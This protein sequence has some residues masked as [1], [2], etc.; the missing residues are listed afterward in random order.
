MRVFNQSG[1][2]SNSTR[3]RTD[4]DAI[5]SWITPNAQV[6]DLGCGDGA[7]MQH[8]ETK[9]NVRGYGVEIDDNK[10]LSSAENGINVLQMDL[11]SGLANFDTRSFD[12]VILS[13]TLQA[14]RNTELVV[15][16]MLRIGNQGIVTFP[17]FGFWLH[18]FQILFGRMPVSKEL[19][20]EWYNTPNVHLFT[21]KEF[22]L[23]CADRSIKVIERIVLNQKGVEVRN[24]SNFRG[25]LAF[26]LF[27]RN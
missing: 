11:E 2:M 17:N 7:L 15:E 19:P 12:F 24:F 9:K 23:F 3:Y 13:L 27:E 6:L 10:V 16:E 18:R 26:Y 22:E 1:R 8:L 4:F 20:Y 25:S 21:I 14:V 5:A